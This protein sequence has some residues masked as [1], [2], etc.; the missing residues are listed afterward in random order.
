MEIRD[1]LAGQSWFDHTQYRLNPPEGVVTH[2][3]RLVD[4]PI[5]LLIKTAGTMVPVALAERI[6]MMIWP[7]ALLAALL[8]GI[9]RI[10]GALAGNG[11]A[12][13]AIVLTALMAPTLQHYRFG[14]IHHH[15]IQIVLIVWSLAF[16]IDDSRR[17]SH[18]ALAG[19]FCAL[20]VAIGQEMTP[21]LAALGTIA[22]LRW[23]FNGKPYAVTSVAFAGSLATGTIALAAATI[24]PADYFSVHCDAISIAQVGVLAVGGLGLA[25]LAAMP[26]LTSLSRRLVALF[27]LAILL[28]TYTE[29][30]A[31]HCL[32]DPY[33]QLDPKLVDLWLSSVAEARNLWSIAHD[34][35][36]QI[37]AYF[38]VPLAALLLG[39][40]R[41]VREE[42]SH[43]R[44]NWIA[45]TAVQLAFVLVS[46]WQLRGAGGA[47]AIGAALFPAALLRAI[48]VAK[49]RPTYFGM[50]RIAALVMLVFNPATLLA[51][52]TGATHAFAASTVTA[53][54]IISSGDAGT[55]QRADDYT[56][57]AHLPR[58]RILAFIDSGPFILMQSGHAVLAAPYHRNQAGNIAMLDM[59]LGSP[60]D[61][62]IQMERH[63]IDYVAFCAG[64]PERY[65]L[66]SL[67][68]RSLAAALAANEPL[69]FLERLEL[70]GTN[71]AVYRLVR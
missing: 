58:G 23:A 16:F 61:A 4:L 59:F 69:R 39:I 38:G 70:V 63:G 43:R 27:G 55:C 25:A 31:P 14:S 57:L 41:C 3:S 19:L 51:L 32:G 18:G 71:L 68:P 56:P 49:G 13:V 35:P 34:L 37:P 10:A 24:S 2:W 5:A 44:W 48:P 67:A 36:Q 21:A 6:A 8:V 33:A 53:R 66:A 60:D 7:A 11:A 9:S 42:E 22:A 30:V 47:N 29:F 1:F 12:C 15:N 65:Q 26:W 20:S 50:P 52:G 40:I 54:R 28:T 17:P 46:F 45:V 64:A 62:R